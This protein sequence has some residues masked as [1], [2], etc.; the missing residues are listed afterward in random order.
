MSSGGTPYWNV[1]VPEDKRSVECPE[2]LVSLSD[3]DRTIINTPDADYRADTWEQVK[4]KVSTNRLDLFRRKPSDLRRY[5]EY[6]WKLRR[7]H[8]SVMNFILTQRLQ[9]EM[10]IKPTSVVPF[11]NPID[12]KILRNDWPYGIDERI[13]HLVVWTRFELPEDAATGDLTDEARRQID[14]FVNK[15]FSP[16]MPPD[17]YIWFKNWKSLKSVQ[18]VEHFHV[19]LFEP[20]PSFISNIT[21]GDIPLCE[22]AQS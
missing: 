12:Y 14:Q 4:K 20:D 2:F 6:T 17:Q 10:P 5:L 19:M 16:H 15:T 7:D 8:G 13:V 18:A 11:E 21:N 22:K 1:N 9:W 3:K